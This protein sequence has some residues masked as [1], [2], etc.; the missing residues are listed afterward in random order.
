MTAAEMGVVDWVRP[1]DEIA[2]AILMG[3]RHGQKK[4]VAQ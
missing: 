1:L 3:L 2:G 4:E